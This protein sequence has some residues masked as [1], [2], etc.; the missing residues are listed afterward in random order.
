MDRIGQLCL[1][2]F[3]WAIKSVDLLKVKP[4]NCGKIYLS[5]K[6]AVCWLTDAC[7]AQKVKNLLKGY[8]FIIVSNFD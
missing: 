6:K 1:I 4:G 2:L 8:L 7:Q 5:K 3:L